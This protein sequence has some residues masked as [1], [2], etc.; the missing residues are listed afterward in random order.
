LQLHH[1]H[2]LALNDV[3]VHAIPSPRELFPPSCPSGRGTNRHDAAGIGAVSRQSSGLPSHPHSRRSLCATEQPCSSSSYAVRKRSA[4]KCLATRASS[5][6]ATTAA[7]CLVMSSRATPGSPFASFP[8]FPSPSVDTRMCLVTSAVS[9]SRSRIAP[10][11]WPWPM[12]VQVVAVASSSRTS[13]RTS[14]NLHRSMDGIRKARRRR[15]RRSSSRMARRNEVQGPAMA[16][17][18]HRPLPASRFRLVAAWTC[19][20]CTACARI[21]LTADFLGF[22]SLNI[23]RHWGSLALFSAGMAFALVLFDI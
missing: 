19:E 7:T 17:V 15:R 8:S 12:A 2:H 1:P 10:M 16:C 18:G 21:H 11:S 13:S 14:S 22:Q 9:T 20:I 23:A 3:S 6:S 5:A 4:R